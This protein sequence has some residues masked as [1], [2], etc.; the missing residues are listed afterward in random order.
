MAR[1]IEAEEN[2]KADVLDADERD[3]QGLV[4]AEA[5]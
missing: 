2:I 5:S 4:S 3:W 1:V